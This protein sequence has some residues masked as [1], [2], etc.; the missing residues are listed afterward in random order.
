MNL[1][2]LN[3]FKNGPFSKKK[4]NEFWDILF[5]NCQFIFNL[6]YTFSSNITRATKIILQEFIHL[7]H[8]FFLIRLKKNISYLNVKNLKIKINTVKRHFF[9]IDN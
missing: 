1:I 4:N 3:L 6:K 5:L 2:F 7:F 8:K 9:A